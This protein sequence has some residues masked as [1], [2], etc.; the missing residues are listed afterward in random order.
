MMKRILEDSLGRSVLRDP[1]PLSFDFVPKELP[2]REEQ[3]RQLAA[4]F[5]P[6]ITHGLPENARFHGPVGT[7]KTSMA[8]RFAEDVREVAR[9]QERSIDFAVINCR[10][11]PSD[12]AVL[13]ELM[14]H[15]D[16]GFP[17]RGFSVTEMLSY[18]QKHLITRKVSFLVV[19]DEADVLLRR[20][21][22]DLVYQLTRFN[23][24][25]KSNWSISLILIS[26]RDITPWLDAASASTFKRANAVV[27]EKYNAVELADIV[28]QRVGLA[29]HPATVPEDAVR[30]IGEIASSKGDAR[31]AI[32]LLS[33]AA[34]L[35]DNEKSDSVT[36]E[37]V[38]QANAA[39]YST[40]QRD[41]IQELRRP[42]KLVLL[43]VARALKKKTEI[44]SGDLQKTY[45][46]VCEEYGEPARQATQ[47]WKYLK[48]LESRGLIE[49]RQGKVGIGNTSFVSLTEVPAADLENYVIE[50]LEATAASDARQAD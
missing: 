22:S 19:L 10:R 2:H 29:F 46:V 26:Q 47:F 15:F 17:D 31:F 21:K 42:L 7:G 27:F 13:L 33:A 6:L 49:Q 34:G 3:A 32:E 14:R 4:I 28:H 9:K 45:A 12:G 35:A 30:L 48:E 44:A 40:V 41:K 36:L 24:E 39:T 23:E 5:K 11:R 16:G 25:G 1:R 18:L 20:S 37:H 50:S 8:K 38:R 43:S